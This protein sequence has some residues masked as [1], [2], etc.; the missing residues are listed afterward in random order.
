MDRV[1]Y[2]VVQFIRQVVPVQAAGV[3]AD[4]RALLTGPQ[5]DLLARLDPADR[6]HALAVRRRLEWEGHQDPDLLLA[7]LLHDVGK[8]DAAGRVR[9]VDRVAAVLLGRFA[10]GMLQRLARWG[11]AGWAHDLYLAVEH[12]RLGAELARGTGCGERV[13]WL[14]AHHHDPEARDPILRR[15]QAVDEEG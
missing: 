12:P 10:P 3:D 11:A 8:V 13:C 4:L 9:L 6:T 2:R 5:W 15:L 14:I 1:R 7:A